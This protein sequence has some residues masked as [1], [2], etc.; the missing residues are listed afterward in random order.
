MSALRAGWTSGGVEGQS[1]RLQRDL[2]RPVPVWWDG[3]SP[4]AT[5]SQHPTGPALPQRLRQLTLQP[6]RAQPPSH[7]WLHHQ[8]GA[9]CS[10]SQAQEHACA[11]A[12]TVYH[13][14][15]VLIAD[16]SGRLPREHGAWRSGGWEG[17]GPGSQRGQ[18]TGSSPGRPWDRALQVNNSNMW[19][20]RNML[21]W[22]LDG[23][24]APNPFFIP[25][26][27]STGVFFALLF[28]FKPHKICVCLLEIFSKNVS[29][30]PRAF[31][32]ETSI[33]KKR[34]HK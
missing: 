4:G 34:C 3:A 10:H 32:K 29:C 7:Q 30:F 2:L 11:G 14:Y 27:A 15:C 25:H 18:N 19:C 8:T 28:G 22:H 20:L 6:Q 9:A 33:K 21:F 16:A 1:I 12:T 24:L 17:S 23:L 26:P 13:H 5:E 31:S